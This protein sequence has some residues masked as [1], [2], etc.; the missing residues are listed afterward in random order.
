MKLAMHVHIKVTSN[1]NNKNNF[2]KRNSLKDEAR[3]NLQEKSKKKEHSIEELCVS[4]ITILTLFLY[5]LSINKITSEVLR[6][7]FLF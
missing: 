4:F 6:K 5:N 3:K 7:L 1:R 2:T